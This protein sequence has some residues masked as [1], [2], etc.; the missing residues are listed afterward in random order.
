MKT[1]TP[2]RLHKD[3]INFDKFELLDPMSGPV[4]PFSFFTKELK[5]PQI[6]SYMCHTNEISRKIV[7]EN[8]KYSALFSP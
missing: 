2:P 6:P 1:G 8:L 7:W 5:N 4:R 3:S